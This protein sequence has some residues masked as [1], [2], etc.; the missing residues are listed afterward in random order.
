VTWTNNLGGSGTA[1]GTTNWSAAGV[2]IKPGTNIITVTARDAGGNIATDVLTVTKSDGAAPTLIITSPTF[3]ST[4]ATTAGTV[5]LGGTANDDAAVT[6]V[7]WVNDR[8]GNGTATGTTAWSIVGIV[9]K[10]GAN[11]IAVTAHDAAGNKTIKNLTITV[12]LTDSDA[13]VVAIASPTAAA[14]YSTGT[15]AVALGGTASDSV[16]VTQ[17]AWAN[18]R[19]GSGVASGT[20]SW[21][22][23]SIALKPGA[24][25]ITVTARDAAGNTGIDSI[26]VTMTDGSAPVVAIATP[27]AAASFSTSAATLALGGTASDAFGVTQV[28]WA[29]DKGGAGAATG[30]TAWSVASVA[31]EVGVNVITVTAKDAAG[32]AGSKTLTVTRTDGVL[33]TV[34]ITA[35][36]SVATFSTANTTIAL[37][38]TASDNLGVAQVSWSNSKGGNGVATGTTA[39]T[40]PAVALQP[41]QN[42]I[43]VTAKD[44]AGNVGTDVLTVTLTDAA[45]P[46][47]SITTPTSGD[48]HTTTAASIALGGSA[49]DAFGV[50]EVRWANDRGGSGAATGTTAWSVPALPLQPGVNVITVTASDAAG[51]TS[52]DRVSITSDAKVPTLTIASPVATSVT[53]NEMLA[54]SGTAADDLGV[55]EVSW[56]NNRGGNGR[57]TGTTSWSVANAALQSGVNVITVTASD[58]AGNRTSA[59]VSV[60]RDSQ[61]PAV[62]FVAPA[63]L[64]TNKATVA[65]AGKAADDTGVTQVSWQNSRGGSGQASGTSEWTVPSVALLA[66]ANVITVT[67]RDGAGNVG[68]AT[69][70]VTLDTRAPAI[71]FSAPTSAA[72]FAT[73]ENGLAIGGVANDDT[74]VAQVTWANSQGGSGTA[75]GTSAWSVARLALKPGLN[76]LTVTARDTAGNTASAVLTVRVTDVKAPTVRITGPSAES[77]FSTTVKVINLEGV[78]GDD[79]GVASVAWVSDRGARGVAKGTDRWIVG[80]ITL[81]PGVNVFTV[82]AMDAAGNSSTGAVRITLE[83]GAPTISLTSPTTAATYT[84]SS[85]SV[86]LTGVASDAS[87]IA[88]VKWST[89]KGQVGDAIGTTSWSI[90][91]VTVA[92]GTTT[93]TVTA[94]DNSGSASSVTLSIVYA[95]SSKPSVKIY[96][97]TTASTLSTSASTL[98]IAGTATDNLGVTAVTWATNNGMGGA[99][100]GTASWTTPSLMLVPGTNVITI[101]ARDAAGN[102]GVAVLT[103]TSSAPATSSSRTVATTS[104]STTSSV[105]AG[106]LSVEAAA[107]TPSAYE[108]AVDTTVPPARQT[109]APVSQPSSSSATAPKSAAPS[110]QPSKNEPPATPPVVRIVLPTTGARYNTTAASIGIAGVATHSSGISVVRWSTDKGESGV[111]DGTTKWTIPSLAIK[112]GT[113]VVTVTAAA[114]SGD[115]TNAV[116]S[117]VRPEPLPKLSVTAP[118]ADSQWATGTGTVALRGTATDNVTRVLWS[119]DSGSTGMATGTTA[120]TIAGI[121]LKE[122]VNRIT[123]TA[124]DASGRTD[125]QV[126]TITY[127]PRSGLTAAAAKNGA[128]LE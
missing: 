50:T 123:L 90:P 13:P 96:M 113:T 15:D 81:Q 76:T 48:K 36:V 106:S 93:V 23:P 4:Y 98:T 70:T 85:S 121:G 128:R 120:W 68:T 118:T 91:A 101:T 87:G 83:S 40:V 114:V 55:T 84:T 22:V 110:N 61:A 37:G 72:T 28:T 62:T 88:R 8:G 58:A 104:T 107:T 100:F 59:T 7:T 69:L 34:A 57:A 21:S 11:V 49:S 66:G 29:S 115:M 51:N 67:A 3:A 52:T 24:N 31:L 35:P 38:G 6:Q 30:T 94:Y 125:R 111:A 18:D 44:A 95:D 2:P 9:L 47:V 92:S 26:T 77:A 73:S 32:H 103:V 117:V 42:V 78:S 122:G 80:G 46:A 74:A 43:T 89:D 10:A 39:W 60:T 14:S 127:R 116:L 12:T 45:A 99:A 41:G 5:S 97:P 54:L 53:K 109:S 79:F 112:P 82:T 108:G 56:S 119:S 102:T 33:P 20:A 63:T 126:L 65:L 64:V 16:G 86:A 27:T 25:V 75:T 19:G 17:V 124:Q 71:S 105:S 1:T